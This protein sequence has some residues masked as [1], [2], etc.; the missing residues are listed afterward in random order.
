MVTVIDDREGIIYEKWA[1]LPD[2]RTDLLSRACRDRAVARN[3]PA[4][5]SSH[6]RPL[7]QQPH[8]GRMAH[9]L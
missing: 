8:N 6:P 5:V 4:G 3:P 1:R 9:I 7:W 2:R